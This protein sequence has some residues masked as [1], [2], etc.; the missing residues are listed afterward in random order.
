MLFEQTFLELPM[1]KTYQGFHA[2]VRCE[3]RRVAGQINRTV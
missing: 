1:D 2:Y 3:L